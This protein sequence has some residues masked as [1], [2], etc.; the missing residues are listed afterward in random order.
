MNKICISLIVPFYNGE[1]YIE[2]CLHSIINQTTIEGV[3]CI[4]VNDSSTDQSIKIIEQF[5]SKYSSEINFRIISHER[6]R[7]ISA[8]RNTGLDAAV[9][10]YILYID[11]DDYIEPDMIN[12]LYCKAVETDA[13]IVGCEYYL[14]Y[15]DRKI[16]DNSFKFSPLP[17]YNLQEVMLCHY[18]AKLW[19]RLFKK[20]LFTEN[21]LHF[22]EGIDMGE[23]FLLV[24]QLHFYADV[25]AYVPIP[26][27]NYV[28]NNPFSLVHNINAKSFE[29]SIKVHHM[30]EAFLREKGVYEKYKIGFL[31]RCFLC[32]A[33]LIVNKKFRNY[34]R[35]KNLFPESNKYVNLYEFSILKQ[36]LWKIVIATPPSIFKIGARLY[37]CIRG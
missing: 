30:V 13:D 24:S 27:Y 35:W 5:I 8:A 25:V 2:R 18:S 31:K 11:S 14:D 1:K 36:V 15:G 10:T 20:K 26:L 29:S 12:K 9:G 33:G 4:L 3:E 17:D 6:N 23:D 22:V 7:G 16:I 32:K 21:N 34:I 37:D 28:Q 19:R